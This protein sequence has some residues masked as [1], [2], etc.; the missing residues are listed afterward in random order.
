MLV[1]TK[2]G[3]NVRRIIPACAVSKI[4]ETFPAE[5]GKYVNF[6]GDDEGI[7]DGPTMTIR[8]C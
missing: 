2:L 8:N 6:D 1:Y 4:R 3:K 5:D 7:P